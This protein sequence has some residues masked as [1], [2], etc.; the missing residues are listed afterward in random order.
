[1]EWVYLLA[2]AKERASIGCDF[3]SGETS[4]LM[5]C[6]LG[7]IVKDFVVISRPYT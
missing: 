2:L 3:L 5:S 1:M 4:V 6:R 7:N